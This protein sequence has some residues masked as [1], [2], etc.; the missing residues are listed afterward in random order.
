M[1]AQP[2]ASIITH[3][4]QMD[5]RNNSGWPNQFPEIT[6][7][8]KSEYVTIVVTISFISASILMA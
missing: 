1:T 3:V 6:P 5:N 4:T 8:I 7:P 2:E